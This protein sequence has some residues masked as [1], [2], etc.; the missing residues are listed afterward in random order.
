MPSPMPSP[1]PSTDHA[2]A[3][4]AAVAA[5]HRSLGFEFADQ[6][7]HHVDLPAQD[8]ASLLAA[9]VGV[10]LRETGELAVRRAPSGPAVYRRTL[11]EDASSAP[12]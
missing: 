6:S 3:S 7:F 11:G 10:A 8:P 9:V 2:S 12:P 5:M 1:L 4:E